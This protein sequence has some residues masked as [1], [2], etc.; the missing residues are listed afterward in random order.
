MV[1]NKKNSEI[2]DDATPEVEALIE[3]EELE[4]EVGG[5]TAGTLGTAGCPASFGTFGSL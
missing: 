4:S 3:T 1:D 2:N 5:G